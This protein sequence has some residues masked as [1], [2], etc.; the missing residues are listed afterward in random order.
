MS[1]LATEYA[2]LLGLDLEASKGAEAALTR[3]LEVQTILW[4]L[5]SADGV[6]T[7]GVLAGA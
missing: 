4:A 1:E 2:K 5:D 6:G 3:R 7:R